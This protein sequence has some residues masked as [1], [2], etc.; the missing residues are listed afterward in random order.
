MTHLPQDSLPRLLP[1]RSIDLGAAVVSLALHGVLVGALLGRPLAP[2]DRLTKTRFSGNTF[3]I[4]MLEPA[5][6][7]ASRAQP[8][9]TGLLPEAL[10]EIP[11]G[12]AQPGELP[13]AGQPS[14][15]LTGAPQ[16]ANDEITGIARPSAPKSELATPRSASAPTKPPVRDPGGEGHGPVGT[17][18]T[19]DRTRS[20]ENAQAYGEDAATPGSIDL[21]RAFL[22]TLPLAAKSDPTWTE[23][24]L[25]EAGELDFVLSLDG[26][27]KLE[28]IG[29]LGAES[30]RPEH[31]ARAVLLNRNFLLQGRFKLVG[32]AGQSGRQRLRLRARVEQTEADKEAPDAPG[33]R[34]FGLDRSE[35][36]R[37]VYFIYF[38]GRKVELSLE[39]LPD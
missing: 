25:G 22:K 16:L 21:Y 24:P 35:P 23:L 19:P 32:H 33:V 38:S 30:S 17:Q 39:R 1:R 31:L 14:E 13:G 27:A 3:E 2:G 6:L 34:A 26:E 36:P 15:A 11:V 9:S 10:G 37:G 28:P 12:R 8:A 7:D 20:S 18:L 29:I 4:D 5:R